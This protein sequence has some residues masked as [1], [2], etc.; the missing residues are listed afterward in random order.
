MNYSYANRSGL[1]GRFS[2]FLALLLVLALLVPALPIASAAPS[3]T[4]S[5][6]V[7]TVAGA[8]GDYI[9]V[10][11]FFDSNSSDL[12]VY[13]SDIAIN[14][15]PN[16]L[17]PVAGEEAAISGLVKAIDSNAFLL[18]DNATTGS[19][20]LKLTL[21]GFIEDSSE[22][23]TLRFKIKEGAPAGDSGLTLVQ[24]QLY[25]DI[26]P[27]SADLV[28]GKV[29]VSLSGNVSIEIGSA[30]IMEGE[31]GI[32]SVPVKAMTLDKA[33]ASYGIRIKFDPD[34][35]SFD[36]IVEQGLMS[37]YN[38]TDGWLIVSWLDLTGGD[39]PIPA[40]QDAQNLFT[41]KF[42][43]ED[44][45][46]IGDHALTIESPTDVRELTFTDV[47]AVEM[48]KTVA[49]GKVSVVVPPAAPASVTAT[50]G[51]GKIG[52]AWPAVP[53][54]ETYKVYLYEG[55]AGPEN[56]TDW[57]EIAGGVSTNAYTAEGLTNG[58]SYV[59]A[60][61]SVNLAGASGLS[62]ASE[63]VAP[64]P[65]PGAPKDFNATPGNG[66]ALISFAKPVGTVGEPILKYRVEVLLDSDIVSVKEVPESGESL[67][68]AS[69]DS[70]S[71]GKTYTIR[72]YAVN[73]AGDSAPLVGTVRPVAKPMAPSILSVVPGNGQVQVTLGA[74][75]NVNEAPV[76]RFIVTSNPGDISVTVGG[77]QLSAVI[78]GL[79]NG[80][81]YTFKA[82]AQNAAG[83]SDPSAASQAV[84]PTAP[85]TGSGGGGASTSTQQIKLEV[86]DGS[87]KGGVVASTTIARTTLA[88]GRKK[89]E[90]T[91]TSAQAEQ[92]VKQLKEAGSSTARIVIPDEKDEV[93]DLNVKLPAEAAKQFAAQGVDLQI[94]T[95]NGGILI[96]S[97]SLQGLQEEVYFHIVPIKA[98]AERKQVEERLKGEP[99]LLRLATADGLQLI[100]R[101]M[102]IET[103]MS[104]REVTLELPV[105]EDLPRAELEK[106]G[107]FIEH[108]D[109][110]KEWVKGEQV[111]YNGTDKPGIRFTITKFST[112]SIVKLNVDS[113]S[114]TAYIQG[115]SDG[116]FRPNQAVRRVEMA[117]LL[118][119]AMPETATGV[120]DA[121]YSDLPSAAWAKQA[122]SQATAQG[123]MQGSGGRFMPDKLITRAEM[124]V[125]VDRLLKSEM[126][127]GDAPSSFKDTDSHWAAGAIRRVSAAGIMSGSGGGLFR[128]N[129]SLT[130]AEAVVILNRVLER[131]PL[132]G[133]RAAWKDV[134]ESHWAFGHIQ[135]ASTDHRFTRNSGGGEQSLGN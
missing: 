34:V 93:A 19:L 128:P 58:T 109:G 97:R 123:Y 77:D 108:S 78:T 68:S 3:G 116:T 104:S 79:T 76:D 88:D 70:L 87:G 135:E 114:H 121:A 36:G 118:S 106:L 115:Y 62:P 40:S 42:A 63:A 134:P 82:V 81:S 49:N 30:S 29:T 7:G 56:V 17:E 120:A 96:P 83:I 110:T 11:V 21:T 8:P 47:H 69:F 52:L 71:N 18:V 125:I 64:V 75:A 27:V 14:Y 16:V 102:K 54:A 2:A 94:W 35:L 107:V 100:G 45:A 103:N 20:K 32:V 119:R 133:E 6:R 101:P 22:L 1:R 25:E 89:D 41:I 23:F 50:P 4:P 99:T 12:Y 129:D 33:V 98:A 31:A 67:Y 28:S 37:N 66:T 111:G 126:S 92:A 61:K 57:V 44:D 9:D 48:N 51:D 46:P 130:R 26:A 5:V 24:G 53:M 86:S 91:L 132:T 124:A 43:V 90:V 55:V 65:A 113:L 10:P 127:E 13:R 59:F 122:I 112:F 74:P 117:A 95:N 80:T 60:V 105:G 131:G 85:I 72:I 15:D 73:V 39:S 38:N 84:I